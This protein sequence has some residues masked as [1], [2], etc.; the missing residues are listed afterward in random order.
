MEKVFKKLT[1]VLLLLVAMTF[2]LEASASQTAHGAPEAH[3]TAQSEGDVPNH[4]KIQQADPYG[5]GLAVTSMSVVFSSLFLLYVIF[6]CI[7]MIMVWAEKKRHQK[8]LDAHAQEDQSAQKAGVLSGEIAAAIGL[9]LQM[10]QND[11][12]DKE[13][14]VLTINRVAKAYSPWN[15]KIHGLTQLPNT[16]KF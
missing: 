2:S 1:L 4:V 15:S 8:V 16:K 13:S 5:I 6:R 12:H 14:T 11:L 10:Y 7:G 3:A 9:A